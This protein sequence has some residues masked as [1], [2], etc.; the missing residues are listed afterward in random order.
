MQKGN[1][2]DIKEVIWS[3]KSKDGRCN[4]QIQKVSAKY[5]TTTDN[6][7]DWIPMENDTYPCYS[8]NDCLWTVW[9][10]MFNNSVL[11]I[12]HLYVLTRNVA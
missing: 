9:N 12:K 4:D 1:F 2:E 11:S 6:N 10:E 3:R 5:S 8:W 7:V